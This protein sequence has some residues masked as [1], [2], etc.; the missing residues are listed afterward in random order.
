MFHYILQQVKKHFGKAFI[1]STLVFL[2]CT[3][4]V[5]YRFLQDFE[6]SSCAFSEDA[7]VYVEVSP[8]LWIPLECEPKDSI[9]NFFS[10]PSIRLYSDWIIYPHSQGGFRY[11]IRDKGLEYSLCGDDIR[12]NDASRQ[13]L[14]IRVTFTDADFLSGYGLWFCP[15]KREQFLS[16]KDLYDSIISQA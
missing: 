1:V 12:W 11:V 6:V 3:G 2:I 15:V 4:V 5:V 10:M 8:D 16:L 14:M 9:L 13:T 7:Q